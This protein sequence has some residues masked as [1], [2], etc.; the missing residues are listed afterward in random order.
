M[1]S[2]FP[3]MGLTAWTSPT[4]PYNSTQLALNFKKVDDHDHS[5]G[6]GK[7]LSSNSLADGSVGT[8]KLADNAVEFAKLSL[9]VQQMIF[10]PGDLKASA[11]AA[12]PTGW[13]LC[14]GASYLRADH[15]ALFTA[16]GGAASPFAVADGTHFYVPDLRGRVPVGM[17]TGAG[18][19]S[20][21]TGLPTGTALTARALGVWDGDQNVALTEANLAVHDHDV[22]NNAGDKQTKIV[23]VGLTLGATDFSLVGWATA[24]G[25]PFTARNAGSGT[26]HDNMQ[27]FT[28]V[29]WL[30]KT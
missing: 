14:D 8:V 23:T 13:L 3:N 12:A 20:N 16:M 1:A 30:V 21:G 29:N 22:M 2:V 26:A 17:G 10:A 28:V 7:G 15:L 5:P 9:L 6:K 19:D 27:P 24:P 11:V 25:D 4:D 18:E